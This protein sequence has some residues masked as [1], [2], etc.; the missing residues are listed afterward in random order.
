MVINATFNNISAMSWWSV[1]LVEET[2]GPG[3][4]HRPVASHWQ[5]L[6]HNVVHL[7]LL[8]SRRNNNNRSLIIWCHNLHD[9]IISLIW[10][11]WAHTTGLAPSFFYWSTCTY[12]G[13]W[14][15]IYTSVKV[16]F[17]HFLR[18]IL[19]FLIDTRAVHHRLVRPVLPVSLYCSF[20][21]VTLVLSK[22][23]FTS[24][25]IK[26]YRYH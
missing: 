20:L 4:N 11:V 5:T 6:A 1:L 12:A 19:F 21:I 7:A 15:V 26:E 14:S 10:E 13:M 9:G 25:L 2:G 17:W 18:F 24:H 3:E 22:R 23:L 16:R 8:E